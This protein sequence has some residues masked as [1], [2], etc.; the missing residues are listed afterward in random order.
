MLT[1]AAIPKALIWSRLG[2]G[3]LILLLTLLDASL[4]KGLTIA[5]FSIGFASD[6]FDG[7]IARRLNVSTV[8][9]RRLDSVV[10][11]AF[12]LMIAT[13]LFIQ[14]KPF[15]VDNSVKMF[16]LVGIEAMT[17]LVCYVR[18]RKEVATHAISSKVWVLLLFATLIQVM[19]IG[20]SNVLFEICFY[21]GMITRLEIIVILLLLRNWTNDVPSVFHA[22]RLRRGAEIRR[23][24]W[25]N[26]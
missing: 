11:Q 26:G 5:L 12:W 23:N 15:F 4:S 18:F 25:F 24:K 14:Y 6:I 13:S 1:S 3:I 10:D 9:L 7:I 19:R 8:H 17:Y 16:L 21:V 2:I 22:M 20:D